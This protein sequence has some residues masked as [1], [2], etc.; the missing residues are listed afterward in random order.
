MILSHRAMPLR[1]LALV[2]AAAVAPAIAGCEAGFNAPTQKWHQPAAGASRIVGNVLRINNVF[3]LGAAPSLVMVRNRPAEP[4]RGS[5]K[6][7]AAPSTNTL[8]I[9][10]TLPTILDAPAAG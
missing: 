1:V 6:A 4:P 5:E 10:S 7:G 2:V 3:V 9:R 8:L